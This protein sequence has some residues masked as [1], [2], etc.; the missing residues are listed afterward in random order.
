MVVA[1]VGGGRWAV[2]VVLSHPVMLTGVVTAHMRCGRLQQPAP[3]RPGIRWADDTVD[4]E[5]MGKKSSKCESVLLPSPPHAM[6]LLLSP[7]PSGLALVSLS[8]RAEPRGL[9]CVLF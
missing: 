9:C 8:M 5:H 2:A 4:N 1:L 6:V 7:A 3:R